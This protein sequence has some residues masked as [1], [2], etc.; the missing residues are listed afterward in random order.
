MMSVLLTV[1][2]RVSGDVD[3]F[4]AKAEEAAARIAGAPG[5]KWKIWGLGP[6]GAGVSAY[7]FET[8]EAADAFAGGPVIAGL[9]ANPAVQGVVLAAAAVD[10][11]LSQITHAG[12]AG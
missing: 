1:S 10:A 11:K 2:Y 5:L 3:G 8:A 4:R 7:L 6:D 9:K 12:F